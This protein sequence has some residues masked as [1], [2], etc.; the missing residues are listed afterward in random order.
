MNK[1]KSPGRPGP[2]KN[3][4]KCS[5][6]GG[7]EIGKQKQL[8]EMLRESEQSFAKIFQNNAAAITLTR[9]RDGMILDMNK[10]WHAV[11]GYSRR[12]AIGRNS[13][14]QLALWKNPEQR[15][16]FYK[17]MAARGSV[18]NL[19]CQLIRKNGEVWTALMSAEVIQLHG[20]PVVIGSL[21]D[22][23]AMKRMEKENRSLAKFPS[24]NPNPVLRLAPQGEILY[25]NK[26][27]QALL[28][29]GKHGISVP[30]ALRQT[31]RAAFAAGS[32]RTIDLEIK[33]RVY[34]FDILPLAEA[35]YINVYARDET[36]HRRDVAALRAS[37]VR[38]HSLFDKMNEGFALHEIICNKHGTPVDYRFL[39]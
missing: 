35:G 22:I 21:Q 2:G 11:F 14:N 18:Q 30:A 8:E 5:V 12:E 19:E 28:G 17:E 27:S 23:T 33:S 34:T 6:A 25:A 10:K 31:I 1:K 20:E 16:R 13:A 7:A 32:P 15:K 38:Y 26:A 24:E 9:L 3:E 29:P 36:E 4:K 37:E 39:V